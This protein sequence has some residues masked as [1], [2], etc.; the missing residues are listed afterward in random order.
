MWLYFHSFGD[1]KMIKQFVY[2]DLRGQYLWDKVYVIN[3][4]SLIILV[5][6]MC[7]TLVITWYINNK[8]QKLTVSLHRGMYL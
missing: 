8:R 6:T 7:A 4:K 5:E 1:L 3:T 2:T